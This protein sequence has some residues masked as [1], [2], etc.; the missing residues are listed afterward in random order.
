LQR[1]MADSFTLGDAI[2][3]NVPVVGMPT[4]TG[5]QDFIIFGTNVLQ[6][7]C[8]TLD[9]PNKKLLLAPRGNTELTDKQMKVHRGEL[10]EGL[11]QST[12]ED[13]QSSLKENG[14]DHV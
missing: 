2:L 5:Q 3:E 9:Y 11:L 8:S 10:I 4:L 7:F 14:K 12:T 13:D 6:Q 1:G